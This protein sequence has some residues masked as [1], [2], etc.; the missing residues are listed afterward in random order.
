MG[1]A[2]GRFLVANMARAGK[3]KRIGTWLGTL[4]KNYL[5]I[6]KSLR[7][8][9]CHIGV[10]S[11]LARILGWCLHAVTIGVL[12]EI[13]VWVALFALIAVVV[14]SGL[15]RSE[16]GTNDYGSEWKDGST[17]FGLYDQNGVRLDPH[18]SDE[19]P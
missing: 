13:S 8:W 18:D 12:L 16:C 1:F 11:F 10:P 17:G 6:E 3:A 9:L 7:V 19:I 4:G 15:F 2:P 14:T 5:R